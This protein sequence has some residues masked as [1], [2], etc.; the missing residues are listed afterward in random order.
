MIVCMRMMLCFGVCCCDV[1][2]LHDVSVVIV[3]NV[4]FG[5]ST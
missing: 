3:D 2:A 4:L 5:V 1:A